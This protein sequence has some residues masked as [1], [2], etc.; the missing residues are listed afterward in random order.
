[1]TEEER[2]LKVE[3][4]VRKVIREELAIIG[5]K[6]VKL[7]FESGKWIG[8]TDEQ[9]QVWKAAYPAVDVDQE[10]AKAAAWIVS[11]PNEAPRSS[12]SRFL[13]SWLERN[14]NRAAIRSIPTDRKAWA[15]DQETPTC[16]YCEQKATGTVNGKRH[17][18]THMNDAMDGK[19]A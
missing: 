2:W 16:A 14:Q 9:I 11:N 13:N 19:A 3:N 12:F 10:I 17:C 7:R 15:A 8:V 18:R 5:G 6:K 4:I 1:M